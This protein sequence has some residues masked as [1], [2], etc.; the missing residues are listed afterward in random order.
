MVVRRVR[1]TI[2]RGQPADIR[3][4]LLGRLWQ[5]VRVWLSRLQVFGSR[6]PGSASPPVPVVSVLEA[7]EFNVELEFRTYLGP[8]LV[9]SKREPRRIL[10][11]DVYNNLANTLRWNETDGVLG[12]LPMLLGRLAES[13]TNPKLR[14]DLDRRLAAHQQALEVVLWGERVWGTDGVRTLFLKRI[15]KGTIYLELVLHEDMHEYMWETLY[16]HSALAGVLSIARM[17][18][19]DVERSSMHGFNLWKRWVRLLMIIASPD[20]KDLFDTA[21]GIQNMLNRSRFLQG[22]QNYHI[23]H[24]RTLGS[25]TRSST[26]E[27]VREL[28]SSGKDFNIWFLVVHGSA[29]QGGVLYYEADDGSPELIHLDDLYNDAMG[30]TPKILILFACDIAGFESQFVKGLL[31]RDVV[32]VVAMQAP[33]SFEAAFKFASIWGKLAK[34]RQLNLYTLEKAVKDA[35]AEIPNS[36]KHERYTPVLYTR[37][38][39]GWAD[40]VGMLATL[41]SAMASII[42]LLVWIIST[43]GGGDNGSPTPTSMGT[44]TIQPM[45]PG[46]L[47]SIPTLTHATPEAT[48]IPSAVATPPPTATAT[49]PPTTIAAPAPPTSSRLQVKVNG[50]TTE[51]SSTSTVTIEVEAGSLTRIEIVLLDVSGKELLPNLATYDWNFNPPDEENKKRVRSLNNLLHYSAPA[52]RKGKVQ[53]ITVEVAPKDYNQK[54]ITIK[55]VIL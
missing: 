49:P 51:L 37:A 25:P 4:T 21:V 46:D 26:S 1:L 48:M 5:R 45:V 31:T 20:G 40:W 34:S 50:E 6:L 23:T 53:L 24:F 41:A 15:E 43:A 2:T 42:I 54:I 3:A 18:V 55:I 35:R 52:N 27:Q 39:Y 12:S 17:R 36:H 38:R 14:R 13:P 30:R 33:I 47:T 11:G 44:P 28:Y 7:S 10:P 19:E 32:L 22:I 9:W 16:A 8:L 29:D